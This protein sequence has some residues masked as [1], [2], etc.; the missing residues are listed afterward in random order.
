MPDPGFEIE[1]MEYKPTHRNSSNRIYQHV[2]IT[3]LKC[4][5]FQETNG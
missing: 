3:L 4:G 2:L 5:H 1:E